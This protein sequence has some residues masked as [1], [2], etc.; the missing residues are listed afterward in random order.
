[1]A[2]PNTSGAIQLNWVHGSH[3]GVPLVYTD[4]SGQVTS[5]TTNDYQLPGFPGQSRTLGDLY[6]NRYRD[7]DPSTG[8]YIQADPIGLAGGGNPY[9]YAGGNPVTGIDP[10]GLRSATAADVGE[11]AFE[12]WLKRQARPAR[13][14][15]WGRAIGVGEAIGAA[16]AV[17]IFIYERQC[18]NGEGGRGGAKGNGDASSKNRDVCEYLREKEEKYCKYKFGGHD[19]QLGRCLTRATINF[20]LCKRGMPELPYWSDHMEDGVR[21]PKPPSRRRR[22]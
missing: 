14:T 17:G 2:T 10:W 16:A 4:A 5:N 1:M 7:Y 9:L 11:L 18:G 15:P 6:Y 19:H 3:L 21:L 22:W 13:A 8:R 20:D 12:W